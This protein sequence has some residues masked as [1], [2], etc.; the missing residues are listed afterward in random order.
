MSVKAWMYRY[1]VMAPASVWTKVGMK[2]LGIKVIN[3]KFTLPRK[4]KKK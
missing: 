1:V 2:L 4:P 3:E